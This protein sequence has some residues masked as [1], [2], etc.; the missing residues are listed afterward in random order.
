MADS[1]VQPILVNG[2]PQPWRPDLSVAH[3]LQ[4]LGLPGS[5]VAV[6]RNGRVVRRADQA[7]SILEPGDRVELVRLVGGG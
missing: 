7:Q 5:G 4:E 6:E 2:R 3:L 1:G